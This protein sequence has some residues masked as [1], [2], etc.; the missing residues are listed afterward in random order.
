MITTA[1]APFHSLSGAL[2]KLTVLS[3]LIAFILPFSIRSYRDW[4]GEAGC[5]M[6]GKEGVITS[7]HPFNHHF[8]GHTKMEVTFLEADPK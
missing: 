7:A 5:F 8:Q 2:D 3:E 1:L 6:A 4:C